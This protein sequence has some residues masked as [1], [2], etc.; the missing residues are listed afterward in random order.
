LIRKA[1]IIAVFLSYG[2]GAGQTLL[3]FVLLAIVLIFIVDGLPLIKN[4]Q[5]KEFATM[6]LLLG[7][8]LLLVIG[9]MLNILSPLSFIDKL[10]GPLGRTVLK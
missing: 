6:G 3:I 7:I 9:K 2:K 1:D 8:S 4:K 5:W 10:L